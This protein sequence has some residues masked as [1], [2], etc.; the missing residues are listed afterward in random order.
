MYLC[1]TEQFEI[2]LF[3][4]LKL[5]TY[6]KLN[7]LKQNSFHIET[8]NKNYSYTKL[9]CLKFNLAL[10]DPK[11]VDTPLNKT[12]NQA[13]L[14]FNLFPFPLILILYIY[15]CVC[16][17]VCVCV[18]DRQID[19]RHYCIRYLSYTFIYTYITGSL[20]SG[21]ECSPNGPGDRGSIPG[22]VI[23]KTLKQYLIL[24]C[25]TLSNIRY[26]SRVKWC[27][28]GKGAAPSPT[29]QCSSYW[30]GSL[31]V[32]LNN[33]RQLYLLYL[34]FYIHTWMLIERI[35]LYIHTYV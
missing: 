20:A 31:Q 8:V 28:P 35:K 3:L 32:A 10:H 13:F 26:V 21:V 23:P 12:T 2:E 11:Y 14:V 4:T 27:N 15:M 5:C 30:K 33:G 17:C 25:L 16:V 34:H 6:A 24:P 29:P 1:K 9:N 22:R 7:C 18:Q 19:E